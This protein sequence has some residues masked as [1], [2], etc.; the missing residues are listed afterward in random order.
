MSRLARGLRWLE[1]GL[2]IGVL[3]GLL[4]LAITQILL[5][6]LFDSGLPWA[7]P[8]LRTGVLWLAMLGAAIAARSHHHISIDLLARSLK[9]PARTLLQRLIFSLTAA[10]CALV[11][12]HSA[13][14]VMI[15]HEFAST[16]I[17]GLESWVPPL[18]LPLGFGLIAV[19]YAGH[20]LGLTDPQR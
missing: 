6:N 11:A 16:W 12:W 13:R 14:F 9:G 15:E 10:L 3:L 19:R 4:G 18:V 2:L 17:L 20:A 1:D 8:L 7:D 5:R